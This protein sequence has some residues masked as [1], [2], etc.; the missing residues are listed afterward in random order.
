[1]HRS[2]C[3]QMRAVAA[4]CHREPARAED[5]PEHTGRRV[6]ADRNPAVDAAGW[7][8]HSR[9]AARTAAVV[10][11]HSRVA[12]RTAAVVAG[13]NRLAGHKAAVVAGRTG[14]AVRTRAAGRIR[15]GR[16]ARSLAARAPAEAGPDQ[17]AT[18]DRSWFS[19]C[20]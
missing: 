8:G 2:E 20:K 18:E 5:P 14:E 13:H 1:M 4:E 9:V 15:A 19:P 16:A 17:P 3:R 11:G 12:A 7:P 10:A 6:A